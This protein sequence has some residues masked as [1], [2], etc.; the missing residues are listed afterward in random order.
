[1]E[2][3]LKRLPLNE[4]IDLKIDFAFKQ[5][6][7]SDSNK[8][9]TIVF[10]NALLKRTGE[11]KIKEI[12]YENSE[13]VGEYPGD[14]QSRLDVR[15]KTNK[16]EIVNIEIQFSNEY[17]MVQRS[18][19]YWSHLYKE[20]MS[21]GSSY[22]ELKPVITINIL[23]FNLFQTET[24]K[25]H[26]TFHLY[27]DDD[28]FKLTNVLEMNFV[29]MPKLL[30]DW[31]QGKLNPRDDVLARW[32]LMLGIVD[33]KNHH[34]YEDIYHELEEIAVKDPILREA[35]Q[36]WEQLSAD[37][38]TRLAYEIRLKEVLDRY[39]AQR[40]AELREQMALEKGK[41]E[42]KEEGKADVA[43]KMISLGMDIGLIADLTGLPVEQ[44]QRLKES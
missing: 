2:R 40:E 10:L 14:K 24:N 34:V 43:K 38:E 41:A 13:I 6:F 28:Q 12:T 15:A 30:S 20:P 9:M 37:K 39:S 31:K 19:F 1:M 11:E 25:F 36:D 8:H 27:E 16:G 22:L 3:L 44:I 5:L 23:N 29:E 32:L 17:D 35:F 21:A 33:R 26:T 42:G 4:L 18:L 7:G